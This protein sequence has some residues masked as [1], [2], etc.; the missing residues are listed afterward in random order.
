MG[1]P[2][3]DAQITAAKAYEALFVPALFGQ[4]AA[5]LVDAAHV[6][7]GHRV[8]DVGCG[9]GVVAREAQRRVGPDGEVVGLDPSPGMLALA[10]T[11]NPTVEWCQ[12]R[13]EAL[14][15]PDAAFDAVVSQFGLMFMDAEPAV[16]EMLRVLKPSGTLVVAVWDAVDHSPG[17]A[18]EIAVLERVAGRRAADALRAPFVLGDR[19]R[20]AAIFTSAGAASVAVTT[21]M[22]QARF[23]SVRV[24]V[25]ADLR[26]WLPVMGVHL[27]EEVIARVLRA[28]D[29]DLLP[30]IAAD[31]QVVFAAPA[32]LVVATAA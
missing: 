11:L 32:H 15:W 24:M 7:A 18:A 28:A 26:G 12:G 30:F 6:G 25:E 31:G 14:P 13:A 2:T 10:R 8:L 16:R 22:G 17:Y 21:A 20:L 27:D 3:L 23:P 4:W 29:E 5:P 19:D 9:T 1:N